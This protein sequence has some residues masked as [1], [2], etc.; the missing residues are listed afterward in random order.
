MLK[1]IHVNQHVIRR[2]T[3]TGEREAPLT[4]KTSRA[5]IR[6]HAVEIEGSCQVVYSPER[7]LSCGAR[8]W[9]ETRAAVVVSGEVEGAE[10][11][12]E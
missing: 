7:P 4:V 6:A 2:N 1:R 10:Q 3:K 8:V 12:L 11:R 9:I 5:N